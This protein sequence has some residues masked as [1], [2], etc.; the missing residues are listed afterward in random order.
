MK[1]ATHQTKTQ[2]GRNSLQSQPCLQKEQ[3]SGLFPPELHTQRQEERNGDHSK[4]QLSCF[5][6]IFPQGTIVKISNPPR[7]KQSLSGFHFPISTISQK[8]TP[9]SHLRKPGWKQRSEKQSLL[10]E[11][12]AMLKIM[13]AWALGSMLPSPAR[14]EPPPCPHRAAIPSQTHLQKLV[15]QKREPICQHLLCH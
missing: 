15:Q 3:L 1:S 2:R 8:R 14:Q 6:F 5:R 13:S 4:T 7:I 11:G 10:W 9:E 12:A